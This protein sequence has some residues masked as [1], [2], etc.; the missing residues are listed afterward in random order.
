MRPDGRRGSLETRYFPVTGTSDARL[1]CITRDVSERRRLEK[2]EMATIRAREQLILRVSERLRAP[3]EGLLDGL[4]QLQAEADGL[5][6]RQTAAIQ[7]AA[8]SASQISELVGG[9][10]EASSFESGVELA[11]EEIDLRR[12]IQQALESVKVQAAEKGIPVAFSP[13]EQPPTVRGNGPRLLQAVLSLVRN[14]IRM[15]ESGSPVIVTAV[16]QNGEVTVQ[17]TDQGPGIPSSAVPQVFAKRAPGLLPGELGDDSGDL[18]L[19]LSRKIIE[20]HGGRMGV[21]SQ[22]GVGSTLFFSLPVLSER[23]N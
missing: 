7:R 13:D 20:A 19:Y 18:E 21:R 6:D 11:M 12:I 16:A 2:A 22:L 23:V 4:R 17:V 9:L 14:A 8:A 15:S 3:L 10:A 5:G 1:A